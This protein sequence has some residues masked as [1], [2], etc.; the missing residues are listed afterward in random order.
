MRGARATVLGPP[1]ARSTG[2]SRRECSDA[3]PVVRRS[4]G[5]L[6]RRALSARTE[7]S[8]PPTANRSPNVGDMRR[9]SSPLFRD[10][11]TAVVSLVT[12]AALAAIEGADLV[13]RP[14]AHDRVDDQGTGRMFT[15]A[16]AVAITTGA[17]S[18]LRPAPHGPA[19]RTTVRSRHRL[20][21]PA[22]RHHCGRPRG[23]REWPIP[24]GPPP[25]VPRRHGHLRRRGERAEHRAHGD[26]VVVAPGVSGPADHRRGARARGV[27]GRA[28]HRLRPRS[29][30]ALS[31]VW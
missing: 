4:D 14:D 11:E 24:M 16:M 29:S 7:S 3:G 26:R 21:I 23:D 17:A 8:V 1:T 31:G 10:T 25:D 20:H 27:A 30:S 15:A 5:R 19:S 6:K 28:L 12:L 18:L 9:H 13:V 2:T 22:S